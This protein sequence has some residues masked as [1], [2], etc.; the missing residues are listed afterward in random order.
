M[1]P[2][3]LTKPI[4]TRDGRPAKFLHKLDT[5]SP[6]CLVCILN[7]GIPKSEY[8][9]HFNDQGVAGMFPHNDSLVNVPVKHVREYWVNLYPVNKLVNC[10]LGLHGSEDQAD[11]SA[12][13]NRL[14]CKK[15]TIPFEEGEGL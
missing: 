2:L 14:A 3:D 1:K 6:F 11:K 15:I 8:A 4:Q 12:G 10:E 13:P 7:S 5:S 9:N